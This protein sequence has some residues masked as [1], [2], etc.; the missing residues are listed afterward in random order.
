MAPSVSL[1]INIAKRGLSLDE[2]AEYCGISANTL[3]R[4]GPPAVK[5]GDRRVYDRRTLDRWLDRLAGFVPPEAGDESPPEDAL[6]E[7]IH[8]RKVALRHTPG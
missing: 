2:A 5:I 1:P 6:L 8:A 3:T 7:A 4:H